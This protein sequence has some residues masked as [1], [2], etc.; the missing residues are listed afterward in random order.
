MRKVYV[1][2]KLRLIVRADEDAN[3]PEVL[4]SLDYSGITS[5]HD[6]ADVEDVEVTSQ[7]ITDSK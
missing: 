2:V 6:G 1:E 7:V 3:I 5:E 4:D